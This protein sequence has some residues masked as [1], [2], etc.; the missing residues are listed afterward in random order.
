[1]GNVHIFVL[2]DNLL[3]KSFGVSWVLGLCNVPVLF[4]LVP[5]V[6]TLCVQSGPVQR[7]FPPLVPHNLWYANYNQIHA[8]TCSAQ[9]K[10][11]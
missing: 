11:S 4:E 9:P 7:P 6:L 10:C 3:A 1:M 8:Y 2:T 5:C